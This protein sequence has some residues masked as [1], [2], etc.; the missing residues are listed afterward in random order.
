MVLP[1]FDSGAA[2]RLVGCPKIPI[3][4]S[5][6]FQNISFFGIWGILKVLIGICH[7][8][9]VFIGTLAFFHTFC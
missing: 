1:G 5:K 6:D 8:G 9:L 7:S 3:M 4:P 2:E